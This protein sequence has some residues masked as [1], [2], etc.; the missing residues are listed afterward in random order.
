MAYLEIILEQ[1]KADIKFAKEI[2]KYSEEDAR[3]YALKKANGE[4]KDNTN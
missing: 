2:L 3:I 1:L 4:I